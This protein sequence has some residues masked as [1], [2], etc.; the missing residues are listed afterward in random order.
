MMIEKAAR[1]TS[2]ESTV[3]AFARRKDGRGAFQALISN[4]A[5]D[6][7]YRAIMKKRM[8]LLQNIK[9]NGRSFPLE[10]HVSNH[11]AA[12]DDLRECSAHITVTVP[13]QSQRVEYLID[14]INNNDNTLQAVIG[15]IRANTNNMR[16]DFEAAASALIEVDPFRR[17]NKAGGTPRMANV[18][19]I[20]FNAGRGA[21]G[22]DLWWYTHKEF[23]KLS[24]DQKQ[25]LHEFMRTQEGKRVMKQSRQATAKRKADSDIDSRNGNNNSG[26]W[27]R[28]MKKAMKTP[29]G[30]RSVMTLLAQEEQSNQRFV[31]ALQASTSNPDNNTTNNATNG[32][33]SNTNNANQRQTNVGALS[34][35]FPATSVKLQSI[36]KN[37]GN[38]QE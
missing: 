7:K 33:G 18:S 32:N 26:N 2:V 28:K 29:S 35:A 22:V 15:L 11:R 31:A 34:V 4:H 38:R 20:D 25:E 5:G 23:K 12:I 37:K 21:S 13:D 19:A 3:K 10:A 24:E 17:S 14:S 30:L 8:H 1:G 9:W 6:T 36:L 16:N 27:K